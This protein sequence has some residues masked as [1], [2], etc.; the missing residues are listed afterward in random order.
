MSIFSI[1]VSG[2]H[3]AQIAL[4]TTSNNITNVYTQ[5]YNRELTLLEESG[6]GGVNVSGVQRQ[7]DY[8][9][10]S[11]LNSATSA[12]TGLQNYQTQISQINNLVADSDAGLAPLMQDFFSAIQDLV[13]APSD[14]AARQ[15]VIGT[16]DTLSSQ[17]RSVDN[18]L[19]DMQ[20]NV[21]IQ[22]GDEITQIN[23]TAALIAKLNRD[24]A[25][26][27]AKTGVPPNSLLNQRDQLVNSLSERVEVRL[28][29]QDG[30]SYNIAI[31]NGQPLV[32][33]TESFA[34]ET[35]A[36]AGDPNRIV[37]GYRDSAGNIQELPES[38]FDGGS[39]GGLFSFRAE[40][41]DKVQNQVGHITVSLAMAVNEQH[42]MGVDL[43]GD[44]GEAFFSIGSP[45]VFANTKNTGTAVLSAAFTDAAGLTGSDYDLKVSDAASGEFTI[46]RRDGSAPFTLTLDAAN[47]LVFDGLT[48][49][50]D[51]P[52][53][54]VDGDRYQLQPTRRV[55]AGFDN[56]IGDTA[57]I[58]AGS[59]AGSGDNRNALALQDLQSASLV[60][61]RASLNQAYASLVGFVGNQ[62]NI[63]QVNLTA[64]E[65]LTQQIRTMQQSE[66]GVNLDEEATNLIR[67]QQYY[68]ASAKIIEVG[69]TLLDTI[70]GLRS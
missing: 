25:L 12:L 67:Y 5:G 70:L 31:A 57:R 20:R 28:T 22:I 27:T 9:I 29:I 33:G 65:G 45:T 64:Q 23:D 30:G 16:A 17:L 26:A 52:L 60:G 62:T 61:G 54:L 1:G 48:L 36:S 39:L 32:S 66:S 43:N 59:G 15:E 51:D 21:N 11:Q 69:G 68:Q 7:F 3:T 46:T 38:L 18:Y 56:L 58:A 13:S 8:F 34:L 49:T 55:A 44:L 6:I 4:N 37:L 35:I 40:T 2:L 41:L 24:I 50:L 63:V 53:V 42:E 14:P 10:A 47:Q 19:Q